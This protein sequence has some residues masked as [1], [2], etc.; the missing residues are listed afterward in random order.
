MITGICILAGI[1]G[2]VVIVGCMCCIK[3]GAMAD[4]ELQYM[5]EGIEE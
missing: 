2:M 4:M 1:I 5:F 3:A